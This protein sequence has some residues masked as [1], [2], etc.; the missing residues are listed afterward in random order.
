M[1]ISSETP[2]FVFRP[3]PAAPDRLEVERA[4]EAM[5][6]EL[7]PWTAEGTW[8]PQR[9]F[10]FGWAP[11]FN[12]SPGARY[13][14]N[15]NSS[16]TSGPLS[17]AGV[18]DPR[19]EFREHHH[20][21]S[22]YDYVRVEAQKV[23]DS[24]WRELGKLTGSNLNSKR[25]YD[26]SSFAGQSIR[27]RLR[28]T[29]DGS[30]PAN[31]ISTGPIRIVGSNARFT[32]EEQARKSL[33]RLDELKPEAV[34]A[35]RDLSTRVGGVTP[36]LELWPDLEPHL[37]QSD[38]A[39]RRD[40]LV[41]LNAQAAR[42][43]WPALETAPAGQIASGVA[44][45][46]G[47][48]R[49]LGPAGAELLRSLGAN[50]TDAERNELIG[51][52]RREG[53]PTAAQAWPT[54][55][56]GQTGLGE[57]LELRDLARLGSWNVDDLTALKL[58][59]DERTAVKALLDAP[60]GWRAEGTWA[61]SGGGWDDSPG[62]N[63]K[64][65]TRS[66]LHLPV[67]NLNEATGAKL[68]FRESHRLESGYDFV[69]LE[70]SRD[71][72]SWQKLDRWT[73]SAWL[74]KRKVDL[75]AWEGG[76]LHLRF[77]LSSDGSGTAK[78]I[79]IGAMQL[80]SAQG[81]SRVEDHSAA[82]H[83]A[84]WGA[85]S[86][87][88]D[89]AAKL[90]A[91]ADACHRLGSPDEALALWPFLPGGDDLLRVAGCLGSRGANVVWPS[92]AGLTAAQRAQAVGCLEDLRKSHPTKD[93][94][95]LWGA[96]AP[97]AAHPDF[98][99]YRQSLV[100][101]AS[102]EGV[103]SAVR[104]FGSLAPAGASG[105]ERSVQ[106]HDL[107]QRLE[108]DGSEQLWQQLKSSSVDAS[109]LAQLEAHVQDWRPEGTWGQVR[110]AMWGYREVWKSN[111]EGRYRNNSNMALTTP[112]ISLAGLQNAQVKFWSSFG[113]ESGYDHV[114][115]EVSSDG[116]QTWGQAQSYTGSGLR[117][118]RTV[119]LE[120]YAGKVVQL[121][122]RLTSDG[123][124][125]GKGI[126]F[127]QLVVTGEDAAGRTR[128][129]T[130]DPRAA[131]TRS[132]LARMA[133]DAPSELPELLA[134]AREAGGTRNALALWSKVKGADPDRRATAAS[135]ACEVGVESALE[136]WNDL[137]SMP[138]TQLPHV[139]EAARAC[140]K[141]WG[142]LVGDIAQPDLKERA[143]A[144]QRLIGHLGEEK[145]LERWPSL[146]AGKV[147]TLADRVEAE[148]LA[149]RLEGR[150]RHLDRDQLA[151]SGLGAE[152][153]DALRKLV[154]E[155][156]DTSMNAAHTWSKVRSPWWG[157]REVWQDSPG[158]NYRNNADS[159]LT[160]APVSLT[161]LH[162]P[163]LRF[164]EHHNLES[165][166]DNL[167]VEVTS[168]GQS[169]KRLESY[170]GCNVISRRKLDLGEF[171]GKRVQVRFRLT[172]D[173]SGTRPGVSLAAPRIEARDRDGDKVVLHLDAQPFE[174]VTPY[175]DLAL[176]PQFSGT[177]RTAY[178]QF[179]TELSETHRSALLAFCAEH[180]SITLA[181]AMNAL[182]QSR[183]TADTNDPAWIT[184]AL[185]KLP[186]LLATEQAVGESAESVT[187]GGVVI[188]KKKA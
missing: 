107:A 81:S 155:R 163:V 43:A 120:A 72:K 136:A 144:L 78:G 177:Q 34:L 187:I 126:T 160:S 7:Q 47:L 109:V 165:G 74:K 17:L 169:W 185:A 82:T 54:L 146:R 134:V 139:L 14:N 108:P 44:H 86:P 125:Q 119:N 143:E 67:L 9:S 87:S 164:S 115:V 166:Y 38:Y 162:E 113:L 80:E 168:D 85:L 123:S 129:Q 156:Q 93:V 148:E 71:G 89:R 104:R 103:A 24:N 28:L 18:R 133:V 180:E 48:V 5:R 159:S 132:A 98:D 65:N 63:Y 110:P 153:T 31:G 45:V 13:S 154:G 35:V 22:G 96:L 173:S 127:G 188:K 36:A 53:I 83:S 97:A 90:A 92:L 55:M 105:V 182:L 157:F 64:N 25:S 145:A 26:L 116:G 167:R 12:D 51:L 3:R 4:R 152:G 56:P 147:G 62:Q 79:K 76:P 149:A 150:V 77:H 2:A 33:A 118:R 161:D 32:P 181:E 179:M 21:E 84:L 70:G 137:A 184:K 66:S 30:G 27:V 94:V 29:S 124:G 73:G 135:L 61:R 59:Q 57:R 58:S 178:L 112:P 100:E 23:G 6:A 15:A 16:L 140:P 170:S 122:F 19:L 128:R 151:T 88:P 49:D 114:K 52:A 130:V 37:G 141:G 20:L 175:L 171:A 40:A 11:G 174:D 186:D 68:V 41:T 8:T 102:Q 60:C 75:A 172:S 1:R 10:M 42:A 50:A 117:S 138:K 158:K 99:R 91:L 111:P 46:G 106:L 131:E 101:L 69:T 183:L 142:A 176:D 121:R 39:Q 95:R